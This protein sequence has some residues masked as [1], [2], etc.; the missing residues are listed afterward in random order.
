MNLNENVIQFQPKRQEN[1]WLFIYHYSNQTNTHVN[2]CETGWESE[3]NAKDTDDIVVE[4]K[5]NLQVL[6]N[7]FYNDLK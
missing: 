5:K 6:V 7:C 1:V 4:W 2:Y 3:Y